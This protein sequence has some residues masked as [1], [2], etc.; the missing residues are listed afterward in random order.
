LEKYADE[1]ITD[2]ESI[3]VLKVKAF[4]DYGS[5]MEIVGSFGSKK[6]YLIAV[7]ELEKELYRTA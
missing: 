7:H 6:E 4:I 5:P 2:I 1:G 3:E